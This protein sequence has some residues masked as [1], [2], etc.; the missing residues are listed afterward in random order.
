[1]QNQNPKEPDFIELNAQG[2]VHG[3]LTLWNVWNNDQ[4]GMVDLRAERNPFE[5]RQCPP[6]Q[7]TL[8]E[9]QNA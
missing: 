1:M 9:S 5:K 4:N 3:D 8:K 7:F 6:D 2:F